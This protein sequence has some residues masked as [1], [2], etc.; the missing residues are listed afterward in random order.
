[1]SEKMNH[2]IQNIARKHGVLLGE[3]DPILM[4]QTVNERLIEDSK[5]AHEEMLLNFKGEIEAISAQWRDD[6]KEKAEK[7]LNAAL[8]S[9]K[10]VMAKLIQQSTEQAVVAIQTIMNH[11]LTELKNIERRTRSYSRMALIAAGVVLFSLLFV[12]AFSYC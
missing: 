2:L 4:L 9:S 8:S 5:K 6:A 3:D 10:E 11:T 12:A 1:M 7:I